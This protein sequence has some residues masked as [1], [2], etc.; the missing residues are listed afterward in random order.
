MA[1]GKEYKL[2]HFGMFSDW[3]WVSC[4]Q[5]FSSVCQLV[6]WSASP[7]H[8]EENL[9]VHQDVCHEKY[10]EGVATVHNSH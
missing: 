8:S 4:S 5:M 9:R 2:D 3:I 10:Q 1:I 6:C 7:T